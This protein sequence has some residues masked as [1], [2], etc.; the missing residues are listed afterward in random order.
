MILTAHSALP[1]SGASEA[2]GLDA[3][4]VGEAAG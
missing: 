2:L 3:P 1:V 4:A